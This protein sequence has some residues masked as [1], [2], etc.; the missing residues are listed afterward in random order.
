M[1]LNNKNIG[2]NTHSLVRAMLLPG[3]IP[4]LIRY[5]SRIRVIE[6]LPAMENNLFS[7]IAA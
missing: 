7:V 2:W 4:L 1:Y 6:T 3:V 5:R